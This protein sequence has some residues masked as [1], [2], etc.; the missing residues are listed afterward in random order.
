MRLRT[1]ALAV[2]ERQGG[3]LNLLVGGQRTM[4]A[5]APRRGA[6][7][8]RSLFR[9]PLSRFRSPLN[10]LAHSL[11]GGRVPCLCSLSPGD[12][13]GRSGARVAVI[14]VVV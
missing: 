8:A 14:R 6:R 7:A 2:I 3:R 1:R 13:T 11:S 4:V 9:S 10:G 5:R 12:K